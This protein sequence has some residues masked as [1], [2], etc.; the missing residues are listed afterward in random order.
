MNEENVCRIIEE[1]LEL[2]KG[3]VTTSSSSKDLQGWDSLGHIGILA[4]LDAE[5]D[6]KIAGI[7]EMALADSVEKI[8]NLLKKYSLI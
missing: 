6:G 8:L 7:K 1:V 2:P 3:S 5:F 4:K